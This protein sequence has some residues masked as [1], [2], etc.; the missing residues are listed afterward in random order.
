[1][2][3]QEHAVAPLKVSTTQ[4]GSPEILLKKGLSRFN[5]RRNVNLQNYFQWPELITM[6][7]IYSGDLFLVLFYYANIIG[8]YSDHRN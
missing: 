2:L 8:F 7:G 1:M 3:V 4:K 5:E 6:V